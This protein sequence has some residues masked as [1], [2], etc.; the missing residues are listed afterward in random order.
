[1][2]RIDKGTSTIKLTHTITQLA[3]YINVTRPALSTEFNKMEKE[4]IITRKG[5]NNIELN[6]KAIRNIVL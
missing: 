1:M 6:L 3:E 5:N 4:G 2:K